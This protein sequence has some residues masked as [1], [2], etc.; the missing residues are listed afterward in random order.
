MS[1]FIKATELC[2]LARTNTKNIKSVLSCLL[3]FFFNCNFLYVSR[4]SKIT[5][6]EIQGFTKI[7]YKIFFDV[8]Q[9]AEKKFNVITARFI[10]KCKRIEEATIWHT[11]ETPHLF[12]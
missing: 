3:K 6:I 8:A 11:K 2:N 10:T 5:V 9:V 1:C 7:T 4:Q 12:I